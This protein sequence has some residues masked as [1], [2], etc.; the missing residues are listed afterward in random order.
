M[1]VP[2][3]DARGWR[4]WHLHVASPDPQALED[5]LLTAA[6]PTVRQL[7]DEDAEHRLPP[8]PWF[9]LR[10]WQG[11]P[12]LRLRISGLTERQATW[13]TGSLADRTAAVCSAVPDGQRFTPEA[14]RATAAPIARRGEADG[15]MAI[16]PLRADG[17]HPARYE[18]EYRRYGGEEFMTAGEELFHASSV[19]ALRACRA[20]AGHGRNLTDGVEAMAAGIGTWPGDRAELLRAVRNSWQAWAASAGTPGAEDRATERRATADPATED[21]GTAD[22]AAERFERAAATQAERLRPAAD[23]LRAVL[24]GA[25]SRWSPWTDRLRAAVPVWTE[26][27]GTARAARILGSHLHMTQ[28]RLGVGGGREGFLAAVLLH[29]LAERTAV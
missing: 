13:V 12:H 14:Y 23:A 27:H 26:R 3:P 24:E 28:N 16:E 8:R 1:S 4:S 10:Y 17:V 29:L 5:L 2:V 15:P 9:F 6:A 21:R 20:R 11:G 22:L 25:P 7:L 19:V 18:P